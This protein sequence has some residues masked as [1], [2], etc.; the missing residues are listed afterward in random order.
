MLWNYN[1]ITAFIQFQ[2]IKHIH[3]SMPNYKTIT[4]VEYS[5]GNY[6]AG[7]RIPTQNK[8][9]QQSFHL[10]RPSLRLRMKTWSDPMKS[11]Y[12]TT[13]T[14]S[15]EEGF[16]FVN[17]HHS[18]WKKQEVK[19]DKKKMKSPSFRKNSGKNFFGTNV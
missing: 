7:L 8:V 9:M 19:G 5:S 15:A 4:R 17:S 18:S 6:S 13:L 10:P 11:C 1:S 3:R 16:G 12:Q 14:G 2:T